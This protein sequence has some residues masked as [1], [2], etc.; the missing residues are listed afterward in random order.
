MVDRGWLLDQPHSHLIPPLVYPDVKVLS[1]SLICT[2][3]S[4]IIHEIDAVVCICHFIYM[5]MKSASMEQTQ[6]Q[7]KQ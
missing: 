4:Y 6:S 5:Y 1:N 7:R 2:C 3:M